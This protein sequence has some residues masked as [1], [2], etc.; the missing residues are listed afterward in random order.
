MES[1]EVNAARF[2]EQV[3]PTVSAVG[4]CVC[5]MGTTLPS[6]ENL[7]YQTY[8]KKS[9]PDSRKIIYDVEDVYRMRKLRNEEDAEMNWRKFQQELDDH[10]IY[11][12]YIQTQYYCSFDVKGERFIT[13]DRMESLGVIQE[14]MLCGMEKMLKNIPYRANNWYR[15][16]AVDSARYSDMAVFVGGLLHV[17]ESDNVVKYKVYATDFII[18]NKEERQNGNV[19]SP[20]ELTRRVHMLCKEYKIDMLMYD[21]TAQQ[22]DRVYYLHKMNEQ[23]KVNTLIVP[24]NYSGNNKVNMFSKLEEKI[25]DVEVFLPNKNDPDEGYKEFLKQISYFKKEVVGSK[26]KYQAPQSKGFYD[27][28]PNGWGLLSYLPHWVEK[29]EEDRTT[30][31]LASDADYD[32]KFHKYDNSSTSMVSQ[33][34]IYEY[35]YSM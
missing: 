16:G 31:N 22:I 34:S 27:D 19:I 15:I 11:S 4:G 20:T 12:Q 25:E 26:I 14:Q 17:D 23:Y 13:L 8:K 24:F 32:I 1:Q 28:F 33:R 3:M 30:S 18:I 5:V 6:A 21:A 7:L 9:I 10:S 2:N 29:C 35:E